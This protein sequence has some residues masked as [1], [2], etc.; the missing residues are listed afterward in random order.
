MSTKISPSDDVE[1]KDFHNNSSVISP[2]KS[3]NFFKKKINIGLPLLVVIIGLSS[4]T[5]LTVG[6]VCGLVVRPL[7]CVNISDVTTPIVTTSIISS[8]S[9]S[10]TNST[11][12]Q[13]ASTSSALTSSAS[14]TSAS[15][16]S[17]STSST[18]TFTDPR[19]IPTL[20]SGTTKTPPIPIDSSDYRLYPYIKPFNYNF[21]IADIIFCSI[22]FSNGINVKLNFAICN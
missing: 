11:T 2:I 13:L 16:T 12:I 1:L 14:T 15:T 21:F 18:S 17:N 6:L 8:T 10:S 20:S 22:K 5:V 3:V 19:T 9:L 7:N 4:A